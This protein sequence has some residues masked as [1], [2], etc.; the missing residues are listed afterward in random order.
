MLRTADTTL[1]IRG[2]CQAR[3]AEEPGD[4]GTFSSRGGS[5]DPALSGRSPASISAVAGSRRRS[6][7]CCRAR[8]SA[9]RRYRDSGRKSSKPANST[10]VGLPE[11][12]SRASPAS[13]ERRAGLGP[14]CGSPA[15]Q[16]T[17]DENQERLFVIHPLSRAAR[18][19]PERPLELHSSRHD[20]TLCPDGLHPHLADVVLSRAEERRYTG[21]VPAR[22]GPKPG[23]S[24]RCF[25]CPFVNRWG[26]WG[27][28][29]FPETADAH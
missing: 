7:D 14:S 3:R 15:A 20:R 24:G 22:A 26:P 6:R 23:R 2:V 1:F 19:C 25:V 16:I 9:R 27:E 28:Y 10:S 13:G 5:S 11:G 4:P 21:G 29:S 8:K 18:S 17:E 12:P